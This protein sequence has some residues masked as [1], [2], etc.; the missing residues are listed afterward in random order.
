MKGFGGRPL[1][2]NDRTVFLTSPGSVDEFL[3]RHA[4]AVVFK[5][6]MCHRSSEVYARLEPLLEARPDVPF[7]IV[8]VVQARPA[9]DHLAERTGVRHES[10]QLLVFRDGQLTSSRSHWEITEEV[11]AAALEGR[12]TAV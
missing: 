6:G 4:L 12:L 9:S 7:G 11:L 5:A 8:Q 2:L 3:A 10:P 1:S